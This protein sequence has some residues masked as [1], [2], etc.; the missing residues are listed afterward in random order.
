MGNSKSRFNESF[1]TYENVSKNN[2]KE[3]ISLFGEDFHHKE[4]YQLYFNHKKYLAEYKGSINIS[5][6]PM[7]EFVI[8]GKNKICIMFIMLYYRKIDYLC[9][10]KDIHEFKYDGMSIKDYVL[11]LIDS[12]WFEDMD[13]RE[14]Y[15]Y[16]IKLLEKDIIKHTDDEL[17]KV[18]D[19]YKQFYM[20]Y[21]YKQNSFNLFF[22]REFKEVR[23]EFTIKYFDK[24]MNEFMED[25]ENKETCLSLMFNSSI[26]L[27]DKLLPRIKEVLNMGDEYLR[28]QYLKF[29]F[30]Y[31]KL[32]TKIYYN[33]EHIIF[34]KSLQ[35]MDYHNP[36]YIR[37]VLE[38]KDENGNTFLHKC[39]IDNN[40]D[41]MKKTLCFNDIFDSNIQNNDGDTF[42]HLIY[43]LDR[44]DLDTYVVKFK[45]SKT[46][47][48]KDGD[49][50]VDIFFK[51]NG[52]FGEC[53][54]KLEVKCFFC[55]NFV[56]SGNVCECDKEI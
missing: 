38:E 46:L 39:V 40:A 19:E 48:N 36:E 22:E 21:L 27:N 10:I 41:R 31:S 44:I 3:L 32:N 50:Y 47:M 15:K 24:A 1:E 37:K 11:Y 17:K 42:A 6:C 14:Y 54:L 8:I 49:T 53:E 7:K 18:K 33:N 25:F 23:E 52:I 29:F 43:K 56:K 12:K 34:H 51:R 28:D 2:H 9:K 45:V 5:I 30:G 55:N 26:D 4:V 13:K 35:T 16:Y 20:E